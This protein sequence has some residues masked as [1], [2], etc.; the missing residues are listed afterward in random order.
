MKLPASQ[1]GPKTMKKNWMIAGMVGGSETSSSTE[2]NSEAIN[3][4]I[5]QSMDQSIN[6]T[7]TRGD[8]SSQQNQSIKQSIDR[9]NKPPLIFPA[10]ETVKIFW[11]KSA[12]SR[13][14]G[15]VVPRSTHKRFGW[16]D[17]DGGLATVVSLRISPLN[18]LVLGCCCWPHSGCFSSTCL[19]RSGK[20][21]RHP[22]G[23]F[24]DSV[25][26]RL[27]G[28]LCPTST[29]G[30]ALRS[31][32]SREDDEEDATEFT[33]ALLVVLG[34]ISGEPRS[35]G[36]LPHSRLTTSRSIC[37]GCSTKSKSRGKKHQNSKLCS[38]FHFT[39]ITLH[40]LCQTV[41]HRT[42]RW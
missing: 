10:V 39:S 1:I 6:Q 40:S 25:G 11:T 7:S 27:C 4:S 30:I 24:A 32:E 34:I 16:G 21:S 14:N 3:Q 31:G 2:T 8:H 18:E 29:R 20:C 36:A 19:S 37:S 15:S 38:I 12:S 9:V 42:V 33:A 5:D 35:G 28:G 23:Q 22:K 41:R 17:G 26:V 13:P